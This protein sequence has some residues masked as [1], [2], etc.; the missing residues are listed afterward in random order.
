MTHPQQII[1]NIDDDFNLMILKEGEI[2]YSCKKNGCDFN[3]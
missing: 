1:R 2:G 3:D